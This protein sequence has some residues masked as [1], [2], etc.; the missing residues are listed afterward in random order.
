MNFIAFSPFAVSGYYVLLNQCRRLLPIS[1]A[2]CGSARKVS[3]RE[4]LCGPGPAACSKKT[5]CKPQNGQSF[6]VTFPDCMSLLDLSNRQCHSTEH[7]CRKQYSIV[8]PAFQG[9]FQFPA[10]MFDFSTIAVVKG[11]RPTKEARS[12]K[13]LDYLFFSASSYSANSVNNSIISSY[14]CSSSLFL[15]DNR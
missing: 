9:L 13:K 7:Y 1:G 4:T 12:I 15:S 6:P 8:F 10:S 3:C 5:T 2:L 11:R 14:I